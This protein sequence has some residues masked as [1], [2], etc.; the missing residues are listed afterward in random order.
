MTGKPS[1]EELEQSIKQLEGEILEYVHKEQE[2]NEER[3]FLEYSHIKRT[4]SLMKINEELE[5]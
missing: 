1:Y 5:R 2:F 3:K 4:L